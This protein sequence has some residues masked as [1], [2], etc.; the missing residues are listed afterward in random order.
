MQI[1]VSWNHKV[2]PKY[3]AVFTSHDH[4]LHHAPSAYAVLS[5]AQLLEDGQGRE[6][7]PSQRLVGLRG[8]QLST[9]TQHA[10]FGA[11]NPSELAGN[12]APKEA[13]IS[14]NAVR[15]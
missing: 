8:S 13:V 15:F 5:C 12:A 1:R 14:C 3:Q 4:C 9:C 2:V 6:S 11:E 10:E 7:Q